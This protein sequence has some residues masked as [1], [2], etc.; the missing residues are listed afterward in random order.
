MKL[1]SRNFTGKV[2]QSIA[3]IMEKY[4]LVKWKTSSKVTS[5]GIVAE[6]EVMEGDFDVGSGIKALYLGER[7]YD[8]VILNIGGK[9]YSPSSDD[10]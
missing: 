8:A 9:G 3:A 4:A 6:S 5:L 7:S 1:K 10:N 2:L